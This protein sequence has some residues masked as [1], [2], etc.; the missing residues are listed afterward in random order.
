LVR[1]RVVGNLF[2]RSVE[3]KFDTQ[4]L[5]Q[6]AQAEHLTQRTRNREAGTACFLTFASPQKI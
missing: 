1:D 5:G 4:A 3:Y 2:G 6:D